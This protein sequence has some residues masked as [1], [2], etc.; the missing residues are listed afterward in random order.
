VAEMEVDEED[1][2]VEVRVV[3]GVD[4]LF[5]VDTDDE[6]DKEVEEEKEEEEVLEDEPVEDEEEE[7]APVDE[8]TLVL[9]LDLLDEL[10]F[11]VALLELASMDV[12]DDTVVVFEEEIAILS[13]SNDMVCTEYCFGR[14]RGGRRYL[15]TNRLIAHQK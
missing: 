15:K 13:A 2:V 1:E 10:A 9:T 14:R 5:V 3:A 12:T 8:E 7:R 6:D 4:A 11:E